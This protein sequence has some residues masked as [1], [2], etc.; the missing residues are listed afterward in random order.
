MEDPLPQHLWDYIH[1][2]RHKADMA[3]SLEHIRLISQVQPLFFE[4]KD[5]FD[6]VDR[7]YHRRRR[8]KGCLV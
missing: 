4:L 1:H 2:L 5:V 6:M 7:V 3:P 8:I